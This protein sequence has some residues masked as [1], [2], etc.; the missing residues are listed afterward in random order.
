MRGMAAL[1]EQ[2]AVCCL[3]AGLGVT[4]LYARELAGVTMPDSA[5]AGGA[6]LQLNGM[7]VLKKMIVFKVYVVGLY[8]EHPTADAQAA[9]YER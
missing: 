5:S 3:V 9:I 6:T 4:Q 1:I 2:V 7:G 8:L